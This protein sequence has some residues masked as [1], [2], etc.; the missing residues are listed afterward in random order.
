MNRPAPIAL[1]TFV[2]ASIALFVTTQLIQQ[3]IQR[4]ALLRGSSIVLARQPSKK[5]S[6]QNGRPDPLAK[7]VATW[8]TKPPKSAQPAIGTPEKGPQLIRRCHRHLRLQEPARAVAASVCGQG[9]NRD[10][11]SLVGPNGGFSSEHVELLVNDQAD[12]ASI[13]HALENLQNNASPEDL[14]FILSSRDTAS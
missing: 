6:P 13:I 11:R 12:R 2:L 1:T 9:C 7:R 8:F 10:Q 3:R 4:I 14:A 5:R